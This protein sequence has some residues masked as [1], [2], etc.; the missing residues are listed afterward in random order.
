MAEPAL[1]LGT[2]RF[3]PSALTLER[4]GNTVRASRKTM[5]L[6]AVLARTQ[7]VVVPK[8]ALRDALWPEGFIEDGNLTQ[9]IY[10]LRHALAA[11]PRVRIETAPRRG[12]RLIV[13]ARRCTPSVLH[14]P[15]RPS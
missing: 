2:F 10:L 8:E 15:S 14:C 13:P 4:A 1:R 3:D 6:L 11:D 12:Y 9:Q 5:E 7:G